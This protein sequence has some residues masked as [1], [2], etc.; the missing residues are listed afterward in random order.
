M[1][2][3]SDG[4]YKVE[5][6]LVSSAGGSV[7]LERKDDGRKVTVPLDRMSDADRRFVTQAN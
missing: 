5:A 7:V 4:K 2:T 3:S 6:R 1:W